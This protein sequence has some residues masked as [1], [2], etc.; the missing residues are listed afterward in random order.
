[1]PV[2]HKVAKKAHYLR[3]I[4]D[5]IGP[6]RYWPASI[7]IDMLSKPVITNQ[8][9]FK[10]VVFLLCNGVNPITIRE[11]LNAFFKLDD[12][13]KRHID[14]VIKNYPLRKWKA[15]NIAMQMSI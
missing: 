7:R 10:I 6:T 14:W 15:W 13:A 1:M 11:A 8:S 5:L 2:S 3:I 9:R 12:D 4:Q